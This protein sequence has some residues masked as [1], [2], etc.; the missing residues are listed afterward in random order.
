MKQVTT[1]SSEIDSMN[2]ER[3]RMGNPN[4]NVAIK[5]W[6][7]DSNGNPLPSGCYQLTVTVHAMYQERFAEGDFPNTTDQGIA[8]EYILQYIRESP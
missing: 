1:S 6:P 3:L 2:F 5:W 4:V 7:A 8:A